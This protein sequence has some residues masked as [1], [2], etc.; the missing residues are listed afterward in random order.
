MEKSYGKDTLYY[1][2]FVM[3]QFVA[4]EGAYWPNFRVTP[5]PDGHVLPLELKAIEKVL[6][7]RSEV[8]WNFG[9]VLDFGFEHPW[10]LMWWVHDGHTIVFYDEYY[11]RHAT[12][13]EHLL[14][15][16]KREYDHRRIFGVHMPMVTWTDH[17]AQ[18]RWEIENCTDSEGKPLGFACSPSEKKVMESILCVQSLIEQDRMYITDKCINA[19]IEIPSYRA[20]P[21]DKTVKEEPIKEKDDTCDA[22]RYACWMELKGVLNFLRREDTDVDPILQPTI[23]VPS[24]ATQFVRVRPSTMGNELSGYGPEGLR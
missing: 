6:K 4:F 5:Y 14:E 15:I 17:D 11:R 13:K 23:K 2:R 10:V 7:P 16:K 9:R 20:K 18:D 24:H 3:G 19:R 12:I 8:N 1:K 21:S 22:I